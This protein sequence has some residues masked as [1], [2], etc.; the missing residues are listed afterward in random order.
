MIRFHYLKELFKEHLGFLLFSLLITGGFQLLVLSI[1]TT[2][3]VL[4]VLETLVKQLPP[5]LQNLLGAE[6]LAQFSIQGA[7][8]LGYN[9]PLVLT[10]L[11]I[12]AIM[13]PAKHV[14]GEIE[15]GTLELL[16]SLPVK[17]LEIVFSL[18]IFTFFSL[19]LLIGGLLMGTFTGIKIYLT[20]LEI[21]FNRIIL[22]A[23]NL[24]FLIM[25]IHTYTFLL[26]AFSR[27]GG[28]TALR[29]T[30]I[31]LFFYFLS[32]VVKLWSGMEKLKYF[33]IFNYYQPQ[34][35]MIEQADPTQNIMVLAP[36]SVMCLSV[37]F[38]KISRRDIPG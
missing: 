12:I 11:I 15:N 10:L 7:I 2:T 24:W 26:A 23:I 22:I 27:E 6:F 21:S 38:W 32:Y 35:L 28:R 25:A 4:S 5:Q 3:N 17:R 13:F 18:W 37:A 14:A 34:K 31:T 33:T 8:A 30:G 1:F 36:L 29:A 19:S 20:G 16:F 9:H